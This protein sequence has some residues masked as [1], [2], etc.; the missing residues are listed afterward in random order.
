V[1]SSCVFMLQLTQWWT[2]Q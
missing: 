2:V 1:A